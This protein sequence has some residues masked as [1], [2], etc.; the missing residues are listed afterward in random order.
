GAGPQT[1]PLGAHLEYTEIAY[2][3]DAAAAGSDLDHIHGRNKDRQSAAC[4][5]PINAIDFEIPDHQRLAVLDDAGFGSRSAHVEGQ[6]AI[7]PE[8]LR[9]IGRGQR[10]CGRARLDHAH[11]KSLGDIDPDDPAIAQHDQWVIDKA[12]L[13]QPTSQSIETGP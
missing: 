12:A 7:E 10:A 1:G 13:L 3:G 5:E 2:R 4:L 8:Y 9:V 11:G 6:Q